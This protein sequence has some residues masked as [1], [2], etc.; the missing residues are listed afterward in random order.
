MR[1]Q[2][3]LKHLQLLP[4]CKVYLKLNQIFFPFLTL[5]GPR[6][7]KPPEFWPTIWIRPGFPHPCCS[8]L[9]TGLWL[10]TVKSKPVFKQVFK[11]TVTCKF[12]LQKCQDFYSAWT[13]SSFSHWASQ[14]SH[15]LN[16]WTAARFKQTHPVKRR[17]TNIRLMEG[18]S[19]NLQ[20]MKTLN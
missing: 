10:S 20:M 3:L 1:F 14:Q 18:G 11:T 16:T 9:R 8:A 13:G 2:G 7:I 4:F 17:E 5:P 19:I 15:N 6:L 12:Q